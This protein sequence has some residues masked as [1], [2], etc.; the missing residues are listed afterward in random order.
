MSCFL[1]SLTAELQLV[2]VEL[3]SQGGDQE[4]LHSWSCTC[5]SYRCLLAPYIF[6]TIVLDNS[7]KNSSSVLAL[8]DSR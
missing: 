4:A 7:E 6:K 8:A 3:L 5:S 1:S 2:T